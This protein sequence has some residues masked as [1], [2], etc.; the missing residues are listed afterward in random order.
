MSTITIGDLARQTG[1][2]VPTIR[3]YERIGLLPSAPAARAT[4]ACTMAKP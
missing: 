4:G 2:K 3:Y 1:V